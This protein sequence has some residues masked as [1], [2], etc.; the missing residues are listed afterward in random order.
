MIEGIRHADCEKRVFRHNDLEHL[1]E[2]L[3]GFSPERGKVIALSSVY[4][5]DGDFAPVA[6]ICDLAERYGALTYP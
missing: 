6:E 1:E 3:E 2:Q 4:S 5:M